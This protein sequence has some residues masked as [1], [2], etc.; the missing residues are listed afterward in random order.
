MIEDPVLR[1]P[2][3]ARIWTPFIDIANL[4]VRIAQLYKP[5]FGRRIDDE[6]FRHLA[7]VNH[8]QTRPL[9]KLHDKVSIGYDV[10]RIF[11]DGLEAEFGPQEFSV[12]TIG[13]PCQSSA[14]ERQDRDAREDTV[15]A[16]QVGQ[17]PVSIREEEVGPSDRLGS[18]FQD[19]TGERSSLRSP[20]IWS[21]TAL[22]PGHEC[23]PASRC[24]L[25]SRLGWPLRR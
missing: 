16:V 3:S 21:G 25:P 1:V 6:I 23:I 4:P 24:R 10:H 20:R 7:H 9:Q 8:E 14:P 15:Q 12:E 11:P 22:V 2:I 18:L 13:I 19:K 17:K 5:K